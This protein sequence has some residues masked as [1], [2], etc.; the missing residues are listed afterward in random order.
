[1]ALGAMRAA[2]VKM[3]PRAMVS[4]R[5]CLLFMTPPV[6]IDFMPRR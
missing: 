6:G 5:V 1:L 2:I 3:S 4:R